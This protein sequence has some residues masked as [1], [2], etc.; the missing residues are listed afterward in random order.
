MTTPEHPEWAQPP[1]EQPPAEQPAPAR[2]AA[3]PDLSDLVGN[4]SPRAR[5]GRKLPPRLLFGGGA[6]VAAVVLALGGFFAGRATAS[7]GP[8]TLAQAVQ[9]ASSGKLPCGSTTGT[10]GALL[11]A[12]CNGGGFGGRFGGTGQGG[13]GQGG[14]GQGGTGQGGTGQGQNGAGR[15]GAG[16]LFGPGSVTGTITSVSGTTMQV[17]TRAGTITVTLPASAQIT[18]NTAGSAKDLA[19]GKSVVITA[20]TDANGNRTA[21]RVYVLPQTN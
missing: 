10:G 20:T 13:T 15:G 16:G 6:V 19:A 1:A 5:E 12:I 8:A 21:Q 11:T 2:A 17:E 7:N 9:Q 18:T 14:T 3:L 4:G